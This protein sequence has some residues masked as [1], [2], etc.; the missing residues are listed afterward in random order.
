VYTNRIE[1]S[2]DAGHRLLDY[3]GKCASPH[4]HTYRA[5]VFVRVP[6]VDRLGLAIDFGELKHCVKGWIDQHWDHGFLLNDQDRH[7]LEALRSVPEHKLYLFHGINP[8]AEA[9]ARELFQEARQRLGEV[10]QRVRIWES[11]NQ[12]AE[13]APD[14]TVHVPGQHE[15]A[16]A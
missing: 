4:G 5:E 13:F 7:L 12:Y 16:T 1:V 8:S 11:L 15:G 3:P 2:F 6:Q 10:V 9:I 14:D